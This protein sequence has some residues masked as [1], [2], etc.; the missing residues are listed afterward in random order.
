MRC[1]VIVFVETRQRPRQLVR[2]IVSAV[3]FD[4]EVTVQSAIA[5]NDK[6]KQVAA[7]DRERSIDDDQVLSE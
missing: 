5:F 4:R 6:G 3:E 1:T 7:Y 2:E